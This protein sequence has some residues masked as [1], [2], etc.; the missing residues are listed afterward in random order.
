MANSSEKDTLTVMVRNLPAYYK[1]HDLHAL[2]EGSGD[3]KVKGITKCKVTSAMYANFA[4]ESMCEQAVIDFNN[5]RVG[6][7][8]IHVKIAAENWR[9]GE[10]DPKLLPRQIKSANGI[11]GAGPKDPLKHEHLKIFDK[12]VV[13]TREKLKIGS[14]GIHSNTQDSRVAEQLHLPQ[15]CLQQPMYHPQQYPGIVPR[16]QY[17]G[18]VPR[19]QYPGYPVVGALPVPHQGLMPQLPPMDLRVMQQLLYAQY[20]QQSAQYMQQG[21]QYMQPARRHPGVSQ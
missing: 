8:I 15:P 7:M 3:L 11:L 10:I 20:M 2:L 5:T 14:A 6:E 9:D 16:Q 19:Q 1:E 4:N 21:A 18:L 13:E 17:P 12:R